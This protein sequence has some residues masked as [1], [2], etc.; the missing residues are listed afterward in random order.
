VEQQYYYLVIACDVDKNC[1]V[2]DPPVDN[3]GMN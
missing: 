1:P 3:K 2:A